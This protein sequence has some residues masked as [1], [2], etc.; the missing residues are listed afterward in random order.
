MKTTQYISLLFVLTISSCYISASN[1]LTDKAIYYAKGAAATFVAGCS[2]SEALDL[3]EDAWRGSDREWNKAAGSIGHAYAVS[4]IA[5]YA[6]RCFN[7]TPSALLEA[8]AKISSDRKEAL[9]KAITRGMV[10]LGTLSSV[11]ENVK[12]VNMQ[13]SWIKFTLDLVK[14]GKILG[15]SYTLY[16]ALPYTY[17]HGRIALAV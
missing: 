15:G 4:K 10:S 2:A 12:T 14:V 16:H 5:P 6:R 1:T 3:F 9:L 8:Q 17:K 13:P 7:L 11:W